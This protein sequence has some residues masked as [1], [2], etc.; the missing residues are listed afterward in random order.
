MKVLIIEA[1]SAPYRDPAFWKLEH[2]EHIQINILTELQN[3]N[4]TT[5]PEWA[6]KSP[7]EK[8]RRY[9][10]RPIGCSY[11]IYHKG[12]ISEL[13]QFKPDAVVISSFIEAILAKRICN[14]HVVWCADTVKRGRFGRKKWNEYWLKWMYRRADSFWVPGLLS[15]SYFEQYIKNERP[16][17]M[18]SYTDDCYEQARKINEALEIRN[19]L[20]EELKIPKMSFVFLF[21]G[22]LIPT[23]RIDILLSVANQAAKDNPMLEFLIIGDGEECNKVLEYIKKHKNVKWLPSVHRNDLEKYYALSDAYVHPGE[24]PYSLAT[25]EAATAGLPIVASERV[26][27]VLDCLDNNKN[28]YIAE[29]GSVDDFY[30]KIKDVADRK[31]A[32]DNIIKKQNEI[33]EKRGPNWA[34][35]QLKKACMKW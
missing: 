11:F 10:G 26:G 15:K 1:H 18:G 21:V 32:T 35:N 30:R 2:G 28:G 20:R 24:E 7:M 8:R 4:A 22:K 17:Y 9:V 14:A 31:L 25:Y 19:T 27:C 29:F 5:H 34:A 12:F 3:R 23:R 16:I 13:N 33:L 6:Y